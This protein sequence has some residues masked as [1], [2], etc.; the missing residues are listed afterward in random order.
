[1]IILFLVLSFISF[2]VLAQTELCDIIDLDTC[3]T[4]TKQFRRSSTASYPSPASSANLNPAN[5][6]FD[7]G[8]GIEMI[9]QPNNAVNVNF[10]SGTGK[11]GGALISQSIENGFFGNRVIELNDDLLERTEDKKQY[12][13][14][15]L[16][17]ALGGKLFRKKHATLDAGILL[18]RHSEIKRI[19]PGIGLSGRLGPIHLG[20]SVYQ[21]DL[22]LDLTD[23]N[24]PYTGLPYVV[25]FGDDTYTERFTVQTYSVGTRIKNLALDVGLIKT[26]YDLYED[27]STIHL[28]SSSLSLGNYLLNFAIRNEITP[29][30]KVINGLLVDQPSQNEVFAGVQRSFG[31]HVIA[32]FNYNF[33][34]LHEVSFTGTFF[35]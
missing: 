19:N 14:E 6:S 12:K 25:I 35:F 22:F 31:R 26:Q 21:D 9:Y 27:S 33:Y 17:I 16:N 3:H 34:L 20:A 10:A 30:L 29:G 2:P 5:V 24:D 11:L 32:G 1:M 18:K 28:Y 7:R 13:S 8:L 15:K 4:V 23:H